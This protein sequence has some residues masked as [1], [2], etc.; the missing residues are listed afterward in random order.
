MGILKSV[1]KNHAL[2]YTMFQ[3]HNIAWRKF[4]SLFLNIV[5]RRKG[6]ET[7]NC[8]NTSFSHNFCHWLFEIIWK[9]LSVI[10]YCWSFW[11]TFKACTYLSRHFDISLNIFWAQKGSLNI[12]V[13]KAKSLIFRFLQVKPIMSITKKIPLDSPLYMRLLDQEHNFPICV[14]RRDTQK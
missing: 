7:R 5:K 1:F 4:R 14:I 10:I 9:V 2:A 8:P 3:T 11:I 6:L 13:S 12:R